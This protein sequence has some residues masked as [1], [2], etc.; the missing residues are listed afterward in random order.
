MADKQITVAVPEERVAEFYIW[1]GEFLAAEPGAR[2]HRGRRG[3]RGSRRHREPEPWSN[4]D[5]KQATWL[6]R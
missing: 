2:Q 3:P 5:I 6:Y 1:F 4:E